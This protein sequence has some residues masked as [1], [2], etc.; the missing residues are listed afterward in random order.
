MS[1]EKGNIRNYQNRIHQQI[2]DKYHIQTITEQQISEIRMDWETILIH[3]R[4]YKY[5]RKHNP[6]NYA[7]ID[8]ISNIIDQLAEEYAKSRIY[9]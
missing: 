4:E 8:R 5:F 7:E 9:I 6:K 2:R 1:I 3:I